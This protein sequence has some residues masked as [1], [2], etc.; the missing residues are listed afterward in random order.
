MVGT[1][2]KDKALYSRAFHSIWRCGNLIQHIQ[3]YLRG[4]YREKRI[5]LVTEL[6]S[7]LHLKEPV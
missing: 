7:W 1:S 5:D 4:Q 6:Q 3:H 2:L